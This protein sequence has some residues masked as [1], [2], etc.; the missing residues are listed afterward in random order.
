M[1][2]IKNL[3]KAY[4]KQVAVNDLSIQFTT[5]IYGLLGPN[6]AGK[7]TLLSMLMGSLK[8]DRGDILFE[9]NSLAKDRSTFNA[10]VGYLPQTPL[11]YKEFTAQEF[12]EYICT[13]KDI[14]KNEQASQ[15]E[16]VLQEV[17]LQ[18]S[19]IKRVG[20]YSGGMRQRLGIAQAMLGDPQVLV[21]D[22]PTAGLDPIER[23]RFRNS[24]SRLSNQKTII[25]ATHIVTDIE[26]IAQTVV[27]V[28][29][30]H[31]LQNAS[32]EALVDLVQGKVWSFT[33]PIEQV[34]N[35]LSHYQ[36]SNI[37]L[38]DQ[39][40]NLRIID[41]QQPAPTAVRCK[42]RLEEAY[43]YLTKGRPDETDTL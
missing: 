24:L 17:N 30:G 19:R 39:T 20:S 12:L 3:T 8:P 21:F 26:A 32:P 13:L 18:D 28:K 33:S 41:D 11:F 29:E 6:G 27:V 9:G 15:I 36:I 14:P 1:L 4:N 5:G 42:P 38:I 35:Y 43:I 40:Y 10:K 22:E 34:D 7:T 23:I 16:K 31:I 2:E 25:I 37:Q